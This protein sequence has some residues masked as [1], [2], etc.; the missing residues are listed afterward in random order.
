M[1]GD[2]AQTWGGAFRPVFDTQTFYHPPMLVAEIYG[3]RFAGADNQED[4]LTSA[5]FGHLR[6]VQPA[7][8]WG[9]LFDRAFSTGE[10]RDSLSSRISA[11][12]I[13]LSDYL[14]LKVVFWRTF[15]GYG[16]PDSILHFSGGS[17]SPLIVVVEVKLNSGKS[18]AGNNDQLKRYVEL[19][20]DSTALV[21][22]GKAERCRRFL[23][24]LTRN[25]AKIDIEESV[26]L[27]VLA[28][29]QDAAA[30]V[31]G[32]QWQDVLECADSNRGSSQ[33]LEEVAEFLRR[34]D[35]DAF[36][37]FKSVEQKFHTVSMGAFYG[38]RYFGADL[39]SFSK[40]KVSGG[41]YDAGN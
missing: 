14:D 21:S 31:F 39:A 22:V 10:Q 37:G 15:L 3:K 26:E 34:R 41:F 17:Q 16:E 38:S 13:H 35:F 40:E 4:W 28:G 23:V 30:K 6:H 9:D 5:V 20:D 19:L 1:A 27:A 11:A 36:R 7:I 2:S 25:F 8:F 33:L 29:K 12:G 24:Y 32:L 18:G